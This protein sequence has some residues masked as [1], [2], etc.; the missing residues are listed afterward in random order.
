MA[1]ANG[2]AS[3]ETG[4]DLGLVLCFISFR[5]TLRGWNNSGKV[6]DILV[7]PTTLYAHDALWGISA[8][9]LTLLFAKSSMETWR[10]WV[11]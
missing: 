4:L 5:T 3:V 1:F 2:K 7:V 11:G 6:E 8:I 9:L 10:T